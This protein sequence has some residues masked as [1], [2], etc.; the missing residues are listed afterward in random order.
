M[1][2]P[3]HASPVLLRVALT[4]VALQGLLLVG[5][6]VLE[7]FAVSGGRVSMGVTTAVFF[8][9]YGAG[10]L[11]CAFALP[12]GRGW[13]RSP[14]VLAQLIWLGVAWSFKGDP[15]TWVAVLVAVV[16]VLVL[17]GILHP[18]SRRATDADQ[19]SS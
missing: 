7:A 1:N 10:L 19:P 9:A 12:R 8:A 17:V 15:T 14:I 5:Y 3:F 13:A 18:E 16:A 4:L 6:A 11:A 2:A